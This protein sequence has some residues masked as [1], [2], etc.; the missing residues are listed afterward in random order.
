MIPAT[1][2]VKVKWPPKLQPRLLAKLYASSAS[3]ML[4]ED[5]L[6]EVG[7][8]LWLR[9]E[10][11]VMIAH[12]ELCC[13]VCRAR[14]RFPP[15][16]AENDMLTCKT[17]GFTLT[18]AAYHASYRH[19]DLWQGKAGGYFEAYYRDYPTLRTPG[20]RLIAIDTL[21]HSFHI[22]AK[23]GLP[24]R[25]AGNNLIEG[26]LSDVVR[27]LDGLSGVQP[28]NDAWFRKTADVM[29]RR[30]TGGSCESGAARAGK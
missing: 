6:E 10:A 2:P 15:D 30:R 12:G 28:E 18:R 3:G 29:W 23:S 19:R 17:C 9:C 8:A 20:E 7:I 25:A 21:I 4:D 24:N 11:I 14:L 16:A 1:D 27:F 5:L 22:D 26:S 13:P